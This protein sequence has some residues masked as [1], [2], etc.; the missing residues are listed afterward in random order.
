MS[1]FDSVE[2][3]VSVRDLYDLSTEEME[4]S[5]AVGLELIER[6]EECHNLTVAEKYTIAS[7]LAQVHATHKSASKMAIGLASI[8]K[9]GK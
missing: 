9:E 1:L 2:L 7:K 6:C 5:L 4:S 3:P 8:A